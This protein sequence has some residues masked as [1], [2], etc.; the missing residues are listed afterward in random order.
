MA[1]SYTLNNRVNY[2]NKG[3]D[4]LWKYLTDMD[5]FQPHRQDP[6]RHG[7]SG[8]YL[9]VP[10]RQ[11]GVSFCDNGND[12]ELRARLLHSPQCALPG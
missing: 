8:T 3:E 12:S 4:N 9:Q 1:F 2:G 11:S 7:T 10:M 5:T 6:S